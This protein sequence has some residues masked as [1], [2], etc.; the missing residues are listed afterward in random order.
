[1]TISLFIETAFVNGNIMV[2]F[3][4]NIAYYVMYAAKISIYCYNIVKEFCFLNEK[5]PPFAC[6][7]A[8]SFVLIRESYAFIRE[9]FAYISESFAYIRES[10][11]LI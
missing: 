6:I 11:A 7:Y 8:K 4:K 5:H 3:L 2:F 10:F 1:M 9:N